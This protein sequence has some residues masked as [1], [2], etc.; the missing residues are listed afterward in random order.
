M[1]SVENVIGVATSRAPQMRSSM[2]PL[3]CAPRWRKMFSIM[4]T[5]ESTTMPKSTAP[6]EIRLAG[7]SVPT[8]PQNAMS[9]A[10]G[11]LSAVISAARVCP[12]KS[13]QDHRHQ[14]HADEQVLEHGVGGE[15]T[16]SPRS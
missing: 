11:M 10:S 1:I 12:R 16:S 15:L 7:V 6:S 4:M 2:V 14:H 3:P 8:R 13:E 9:S 5:V